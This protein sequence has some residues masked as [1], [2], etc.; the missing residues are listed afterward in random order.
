M[1]FF[2]EILWEISGIIQTLYFK[3][4]ICLSCS[5][6]SK[7]CCNVNKFCVN[8]HQPK[9]ELE[10]ATF[11]LLQVCIASAIVKIWSYNLIV[12]KIIV[13]VVFGEW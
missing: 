9:S 13:A 1:P 4:Y 8:K 5:L 11:I 12:N 3:T 10:K 7:T 6:Y 2:V